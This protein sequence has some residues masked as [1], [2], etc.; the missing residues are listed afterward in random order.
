[1]IHTEIVFL[2]EDI[3]RRM[4]RERE[5]ESRN[6]EPVVVIVYNQCFILLEDIVS[7]MSDKSLLPFELLEPINEQI[8]VINNHQ[9]MTDLAYDVSQLNQV[10]S[11]GVSKFN[12]DQKKVYES[13]LNIVDSNSGQLFFLDAPG[14][15]V[16]TFLINLLLAKFR[17]GKDIV[18][19]LALSGIAATC[20]NKSLGF[21][22]MSE[23][24]FFNGDPKCIVTYDLHPLSAFLSG[25][26]L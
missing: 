24:L 20:S 2:R 16:K 6:V 8:I 14:E 10:V 21:P 11:V 5:R 15:T 1:M 13:D 26:K 9:S 25:P 17:S 18:I 22:G 7:S 19:A 3:Q 12:H 23:E 4:K